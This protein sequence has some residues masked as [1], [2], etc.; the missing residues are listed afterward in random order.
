[1]TGQIWTV[2]A[3]ILTISDRSKAES[4]RLADENDMV[5]EDAPELP[6]ELATLISSSAFV[7]APWCTCF[8]EF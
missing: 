8:G 3:D 1:M 7:G 6:S 4:M 2:E 5:S